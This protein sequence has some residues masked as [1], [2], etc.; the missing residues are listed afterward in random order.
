MRGVLDVPVVAIH[1][2]IQVALGRVCDI[3]TMK[4]GSINMRQGNA[5]RYQWWN[6]NNTGCVIHTVCENRRPSSVGSMI[7]SGRL[8]L[9]L[10]QTL[11][12]PR[13]LQPVG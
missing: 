9:H 12:A 13:Y 2:S 8:N 11:P 5:F 7:P 1:S 10:S 4:M 6:M 3:V